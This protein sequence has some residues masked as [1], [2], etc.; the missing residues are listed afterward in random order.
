[1]EIQKMLQTLILAG[2]LR[3]EIDEKK[4][5]DCLSKCG[6][7]H[8]EGGGVHFFSGLTI[9][10]YSIISGIETM[11]VK[12]GDLTELIKYFVTHLSV[13]FLPH[14]DIKP[15]SYFFSSSSLHESETPN[16]LFTWREMQLLNQLRIIG[17]R[18]FIVLELCG[19]ISTIS[20]S[21][22]NS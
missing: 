22:L 17:K 18:N 16:R 7:V 9:L 21:I 11:D 14:F 1:V 6:V 3:V 10:L 13:R 15:F 8:M 20:F 2:N 4:L 12:G 5:W 19:H